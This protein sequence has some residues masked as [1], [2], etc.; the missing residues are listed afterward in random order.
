MFTDI[1]KVAELMLRFLDEKG[2]SINLHDKEA[3]PLSMVAFSYKPFPD[4]GP[5]KEI[6]CLFPPLGSNAP[7]KSMNYL[8]GKWA[9]THECAERRQRETRLMFEMAGSYLYPN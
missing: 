5:A 1:G 4:H 7:E 3:Y 9:F 2:G 6:A 8:F